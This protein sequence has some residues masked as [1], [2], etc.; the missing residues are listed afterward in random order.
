MKSVPMRHRP[1]FLKLIKICA[2]IT[3]VS[4]VIPL[5]TVP[6]SAASYG[7]NLPGNAAYINDKSDLDMLTS[8]ESAVFF[9][10]G[11]NVVGK[12]GK[13]LFALSKL[14]KY[15]PAGVLPVLSVG[16]KDA[17]N[18][19]AFLK[20][21]YPGDGVILSQSASALTSVFKNYPT[22]FRVLDKMGAYSSPLTDEQ[23]KKLCAE[24]NKAHS[25]AV[26][27]SGAALTRESV[28]KL[29]SRFT[30]V[31]GAVNPLKTTDQALS[32]L[33]SGV[34]CA[35]TDAPETVRSAAELLG[36][37][38]VVRAPMFV[39]H[40]SVVADVPENSIAAFTLA[41][42]AGVDFIETDV[43]LS[44]DGI[45]VIIHSSSVDYMTEGTGKVEE[46]TLAE[47][48]ELHLWGPGD[49]FRETY[50]DERIPTLAEFFDLMK[51]SK[52]RVF[53][54]IKSDN[55]AICQLVADMITKY[56]Y[57][58]RMVIIGFNEKLLAKIRKLLPSVP[59]GALYSAG[60]FATGTVGERLQKITSYDCFADVGTV[61]GAV[62]AEYLHGAALRGIPVATWTYTADMAEA[63]SEHFLAGSDGL[64][65]EV[66]EGTGGVLRYLSAEYSEPAVKDDGSSEVTYRVTAHYYDGST[67]DVTASAK[68]T[69]FGAPNIS[70]ADGIITVSSGKEN[71]GVIFGVEGVL[72]DGRGYSVFTEPFAV[73]EEAV[74]EEPE[75]IAPEK[76]QPKETTS[77]TAP[78]DVTEPGDESD[79]EEPEEIPEESFD[80]DEVSEDEPTETAPAKRSSSVGYWVLFAVCVTVSAAA[81]VLLIIKKKK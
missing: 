13:T 53:L 46:K 31:W 15:L 35:V 36:D 76:P 50:P 48:K 49:I 6:A 2:V 44:A 21:N 5:F 63:Y 68:P 37:M 26:L 75:P 25:G 14:S 64:T 62:T 33:C 22:V 28:D 61:F 9:V 16:S 1:L 77:D 73:A 57:E 74:P 27:L 52:L 39:S 45:P 58:D 7:I 12:N 3:A 29:R 24:V 38:P 23:A 51:S 59:C 11:K 34:S 18:A 54:E 19:A 41:D 66:I 43:Y 72:P 10:S 55:E 4:L 30:S 56:G 20:K 81:L 8:A 42:A 47:L 70:A 67:A 69:V 60:S 40:R 32:L 17:L 79:I 71:C 80:T 65:A 78:T